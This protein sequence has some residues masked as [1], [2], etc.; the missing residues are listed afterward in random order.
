MLHIHMYKYASL[1]NFLLGVRF[2]LSV[3][4]SSRESTI[5]LQVHKSCCTWTFI[6]M[7]SSAEK[8]TIKSQ[9]YELAHLPGVLGLVDGT[10][11]RIQKSSEDEAD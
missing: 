5:S 7:P 2:K 10:H 6:S 11:I 4:W 8:A 1:Y 9:F 3:R